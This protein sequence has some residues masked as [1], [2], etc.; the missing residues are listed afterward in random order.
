MRSAANQRE[1]WWWRK[2]ARKSWRPRRK[3]CS[4]EKRSRRPPCGNSQTPG[5]T[6]VPP[7]STTASVTHR[8][9]QEDGPP[10]AALVQAWRPPSGPPWNWRA[11]FRAARMAR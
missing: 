11:Y 10:T 3:A 6:S 5:V 8:A 1:N 9:T 7:Q 4:V 2:A